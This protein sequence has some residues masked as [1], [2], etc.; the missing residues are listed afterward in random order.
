MHVL[1]QDSCGCQIWVGG[2]GTGDSVGEPEFGDG[3]IS[4]INSDRGHVIRA[5]ET[6]K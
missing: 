1:I 2:D 6:G 3:H 5:G 4:Q